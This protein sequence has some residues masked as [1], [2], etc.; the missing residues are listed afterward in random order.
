MPALKSYRASLRGLEDRAKAVASVTHASEA[1][2]E[3]TL[4]FGDDEAAVVNLLHL[5]QLGTASF[6]L[7]LTSDVHS[8]ETRQAQSVSAYS[9]MMF[10]VN[11][12]PSLLA[13]VRE[14]SAIDGLRSEDASADS[15]VL[16]LYDSVESA[17][18]PDRLARLIDA[19]DML[20]A[21]CASLL[22]Q[23][24]KSQPQNIPLQLM[25][26]S[27]VAI[28]S[29]VFRGDAL[30]VAAAQKVILYL[31]QMSEESHKD[32]VYSVESIADSM[33]FAEL[34]GEILQLE[35]NKDGVLGAVTK[36]AKDSAIML[37]ECGAQ[38]ASVDSV[39]DSGV[40]PST[41]IAKLDADAKAFDAIDNKVNASIVKRYDQVYE[42]ERD[43]LINETD[44]NDAVDDKPE[45]GSARGKRG[46]RVAIDSDQAP[47]MRKD[48]I[49][50]LIIDLN[51][52]YSEQR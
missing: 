5:G 33:P 41:V 21:N 17:S 13:L 11:H 28:R 22:P 2:L 32:T 40:L 14:S 36:N 39:A 25:S 12:L 30:L 37:L 43:K 24:L 26:V 49:D 29:V 35:E 38:L 6:W 27:G 44:A 51:R 8:V 48:S 23:Q 50:D 9:K 19:V 46:A 16:R 31:N 45:T 52:L 47:P 34:V 3:K 1:Y 15:L 7:D 42:R 4:M 20:Y 18:S 10:A